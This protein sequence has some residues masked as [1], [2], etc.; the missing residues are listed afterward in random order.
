[1]VGLQFLTAIHLHGAVD[2]AVGRYGFQIL[3]FHYH[4]LKWRFLHN[5]LFQF[6]C[7][8]RSRAYVSQGC[9]AAVRLLRPAWHF[10]TLYVNITTYSKS[11]L[12]KLCI[13]VMYCICHTCRARQSINEA[14]NMYSLTSIW[15]WS[16]TSLF[17]RLPPSSVCMDEDEAR[18]FKL[19]YLT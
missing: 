2:D 13:C 17:D 9:K 15:N 16:T 5:L 11:D 8:L 3:R 7:W 1:M 10:F 19:K 12:L 18:R 14:L 4:Y 6:M